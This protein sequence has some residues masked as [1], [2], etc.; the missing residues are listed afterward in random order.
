MIDLSRLPE[1]ASPAEVAEV[2]RCSKRYVQSLCAD[3]R[4]GAKL[5]A[6]RYLILRSAVDAFL[7]E[8]DVVPCPSATQVPIS[9]GVKIVKAGKSSG[10]SGVPGDASPALQEIAESLINSSRSTSR[11]HHPPAQVIRLSDR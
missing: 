3:G 9:N 7:A 2:L 4:L 5:I 10:T 1:L 6:S 8:A 11:R